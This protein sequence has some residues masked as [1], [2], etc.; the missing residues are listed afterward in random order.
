M[1]CVNMLI[2]SVLC[3]SWDY[4]GICRI[5]G[6]QRCRCNSVRHRHVCLFILIYN[7]LRVLPIDFDIAQIAIGVGIAIGLAMPLASNILPIRVCPVISLNDQWLI[8]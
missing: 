2:G 6:I 4:Y 1:G 5:C 8:E 3:C 7:F